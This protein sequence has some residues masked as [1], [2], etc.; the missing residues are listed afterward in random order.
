[1]VNFFWSLYFFNLRAYGFSFLWL[2]LLL[3][4]IIV[5]IWVFNKVDKPSA[6]IQTPYLIWVTFAGYLNFAVWYLNRA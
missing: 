4:L 6:L 1:M 5:M 2:M 3:A